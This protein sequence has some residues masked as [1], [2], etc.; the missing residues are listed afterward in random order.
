M[1]LSVTAAKLLPLQ[2]IYFKTGLSI[3]LLSAAQ[4]NPN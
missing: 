3:L 1:K 2:F 4:A